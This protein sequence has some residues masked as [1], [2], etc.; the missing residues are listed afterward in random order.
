MLLTRLTAPVRH[1]GE[2]D[3]EPAGDL[4]LT[5]VTARACDQ[6]ALAQ[7]KSALATGI[8]LQIQIS[9]FHNFT[10]QLVRGS[11]TQIVYKHASRPLAQ[12]SQ[13]D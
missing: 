5:E 11:G 2:T 1:R 10:V 13:S 6:N 3:L 7:I 4:D 9:S 8:R 12:Q